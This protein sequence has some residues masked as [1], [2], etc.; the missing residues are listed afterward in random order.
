MLN[1]RFF[2]HGKLELNVEVYSISYLPI[3]EELFSSDSFMFALIGLVIAFVIGIR[4][5]TAKKNIIG[6]CVCLVVYVFAE[7]ISN[8]IKGNYLL[9][10]LLL[11]AGTIAIGGVIGSLGGFVVSKIRNKEG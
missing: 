2:Q 1:F 7:V 8:L 11:I 5:K 6:F 4:M 10:I 3:L 9:D